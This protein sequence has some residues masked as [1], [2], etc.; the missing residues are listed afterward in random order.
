[1]SE[2]SY[3]YILT[4]RVY[5]FSYLTSFSLIFLNHQKNEQGETESIETIYL[6]LDFTDQ[7]WK[8]TKKTKVVKS[9]NK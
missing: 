3:K 9:P 2:I 8:K 7:T 5:Y 6:I 1:M 4:Q